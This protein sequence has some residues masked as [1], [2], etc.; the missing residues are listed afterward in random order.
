MSFAICEDEAICTELLRCFVAT[1]SIR[2][3]PLNEYLRPVVMFDKEIV[4]CL[5]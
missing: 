1:F 4:Q 3:F 5:C 2:L